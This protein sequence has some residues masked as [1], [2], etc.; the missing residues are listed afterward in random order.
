MSTKAETTY[1][2][3]GVTGTLCHMAMPAPVLMK[4]GSSIVP[5]A[6]PDQASVVLQENWG[7]PAQSSGSHPGVPASK[8]PLATRV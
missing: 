4:F 6:T 7:W 3:D 5:A 8:S 1:G 2:V